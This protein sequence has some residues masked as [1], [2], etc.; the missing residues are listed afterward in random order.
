MNIGRRIKEIYDVDFSRLIEELKMMNKQERMMIYE[1][2]SKRLFPKSKKTITLEE[3]LNDNHKVDREKFRM[4]FRVVCGEFFST[5][6]FGEYCKRRFMKKTGLNTQTF[7]QKVIL[8]LSLM[9]YIREQGLKCNYSTGNHGYIYQVD[10]MKFCK[11][12]Q[13]LFAESVVEDEAADYD[14]PIREEY[15]DLEQEWLVEKQLKTIRSISVDKGV[16]RSLMKIKD[17]YLSNPDT[18][19]WHEKELHHINNMERLYYKKKSNL[20]ITIDGPEGRLYSVMTNL[21]SDWRTNGSIHI[22][23]E[24]FCEV[25]MSSLHPTL[26]GLHIREKYPDIQSLWMEHCL[27]GDFYEWVIDVTELE[28]YSV[29]QMV[30]EL[31][32]IIPIGWKKKHENKSLKDKANKTERIIK[33]IE[34]EESEDKHRIFRPVVKCWIMGLL[35]SK[36]KLSSTEKD[37]ASIYKHFCHNLCMYLKENEPCIYQELDRYRSNPIPKRR[38]PN[39]MVSEL[40]LIMQQEEVRFIK[41]CLRHLDKEVQYLYTIHDCVGCLESDAALVKQIMEQTSLEMYGFRLNLKI[42]GGDDVRKLRLAS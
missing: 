16:F 26:F 31:G 4:C 20:H 17:E 7:P 2:H 8:A 24:R 38:D 36:F 29:E 3:Q 32:R 21:N 9:G 22:N 41:R 15:S 25:D 39:K 34:N 35:F 11:M 28:Q 40:P 1:V 18:K 33:D 12:E 5:D 30:M 23:G 13:D 19:T 6:H 42:E 37:G 14:V 10:Y 27:A